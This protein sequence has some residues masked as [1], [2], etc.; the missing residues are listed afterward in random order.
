MTDFS[1][2]GSMSDRSLAT[3]ALLGFKLGYYFPRA[4]WFGIETELYHTTPHIKQQ[5]TTIAIQSGSVLRE[6][7]PVPGGTS[8]GVLSGD[9]FRVLTWVPV[10][11]MFRYYKTRLQPYFGFGPGVF[12]GRI[13]TT[14]PQFAGSQ[15]ST[16][17]GLNAK[18][19]GEY[20]FTRHLTAFAEIKYNYTSF[21][22]AANSNGGFGFKATYNP[23]FLAFGVSYHF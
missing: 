6:F 22:F 19:G 20:F 7:G 18:L 3:S 12:M 21:D 9:N 1:P 5:P 13:T 11:F 10:N 2:A 15:N 23:I 8:T 17:L 4:R 14:I 16:R